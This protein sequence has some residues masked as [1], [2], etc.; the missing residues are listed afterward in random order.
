MSGAFPVINSPV[1]SAVPDLR[2]N[3]KG[4]RKSMKIKINESRCTGCGVC[5]D[6]CPEIFELGDSG[7]AYVKDPEFDADCVKEARDSC[8]S[9]AIILEE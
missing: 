3:K 6:I 2:G 5:V 9:E 4:A 7:L 8:P 1:P